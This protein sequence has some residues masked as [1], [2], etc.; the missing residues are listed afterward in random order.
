[1]KNVAIIG[2]GPAGLFTSNILGTAC[3]DL[4]NATIFEASERVG[5]KV[6]TC[7]FRTVP[8]LYEAGVAELYDY[9]RFGDD[10][11]R[12]LIEHLGLSTIPMRG[13]TV[14]L[15]DKVLNTNRDIRRKFGET[16]LAAINSF[17]KKCEALCNAEDYYEDYWRGEKLH[18]WANRTFAE[19]LNGIPDEIAR[20]YVATAAHADVAAAPYLTSALNG[21]KNVLMDNNHYL[22]LYCIKGGN[23]CLVRR[24]AE[25]ID[26]E[27]ILNSPVIKIGKTIDHR[28]RVTF[29]KNGAVGQRDFDF[30]VLALPNYWLQGLDFEG[31]TLR[32]AMETHLAH[33]DRPAHYLRVSCLFKEPFWRKKV[34]G[35]FFMQDVF[36]GVCLYDEGARQD[37]MGYGVLGWLLAGTE[38]L[39]LSNFDDETLTRYVLDTLPKPLAH[40][41]HLLI[42]SRVHRWVG[43]VSAVPGGFPV[44]EL[45]QRH[46]P[47]PEEHPGLLVVGDYLF[48]STVNAAYDSA[49]FAT[50]LLLTEL[51]RAQYAVLNDE[52]IPSPK[53]CGALGA[54]Y[55]DEYADDQ[56]YEEASRV[57]L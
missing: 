46:Q 19:L 18:P 56:T 7:S 42:E 48:D 29:R 25:T 8:I 11:L 30:I 49:D 1:M 23:E 15:G 32:R 6:V 24:L 14:I 16:T 33:Y 27:I 35:D 4:C 52:L 9:S 22:K 50:D 47:E 5:G 45:R 31:R 44:Q 38:A 2:A 36:G 41:R 26:A 17:H 13:R 3:G 12:K 54:A 57:F 21:I 39:A 28:Y 51:R 34:K 40:G 20:R 10:P 43:T 53:N 55:H 37:D